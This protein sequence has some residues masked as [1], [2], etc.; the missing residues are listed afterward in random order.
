MSPYHRCR[1]RRSQR[2]V[3]AIEYAMAFLLFFGLVYSII[4]YSI[5]FTFRF[6][7]QNAAE[8]GARAALRHQTSLA[9]RQLKAQEVAEQRSL[10]WKPADAVL[11]I[12]LPSICQTGSGNCLQPAGTLACDTS[13]AQR[14]H[15]SVTVRLSDLHRVL[16][17]FPAFALPDELV[18]EAHVLLDGSRL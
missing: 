12:P 11:T 18:G 9:A 15:V 14:C 3:Y 10:G 16:P 7:L 2:G 17:P 4:C 13:W 1:R 5:V 8:D 6:G